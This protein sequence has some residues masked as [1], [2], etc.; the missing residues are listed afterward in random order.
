MLLLLFPLTVLPQ[1]TREKLKVGSSTREMLVYVPAGLPEYAPLVISMHGMNQDAAYQKGMANWAAVADTAKFVVVYPEGEG[2]SWDIGGDKDTK[3]IEAIIDEMFEKHHI[4][5]NRVYLSGF[6]MGGMM[7][8]HAASLISSKLAALAPISGYAMDGSARCPRQIPVIHT[9]GTD[10]DVVAYSGAEPYL[11]KWVSIDGCD[12]GPVTIK[13]YKGKPNASMKVWTNTENGIEVALLTLDGKGHWVSMDAS[14]VL[15]SCEI[16]NFC[17]RYSLDG[18]IEVVPP[19]LL[20]VTP[21]DMSFDLPDSC[22][23]FKV[24]FNKPIQCDTVS[25]LLSGVGGTFRL[26]LQEEGVSETLTFAL[27]VGV[28]LPHGEYDLSLVNV[29]DTFGGVN[30][31]CR[32][33]FGIGREPVDGEF[34]P[35]VIY[36]PD[37]MSQ[38]SIIGE[39]IPEG[40]K[41]VNSSADGRRDEKG[42]NQPNTG[43][44]RLKY[45]QPGGDMDAVFYLSARDY[46]TGSIYY[47]TYPDHRLFLK[48]GNYELSFN[49][50]YWT[51]GA[52][53]NAMTFSMAVTDL[54]GNVVFEQVG[55]GSSGA[56]NENV[57]R[58]ITGSKKHNIQ[59]RVTGDGYYVLRFT[60]SSGWDGV[61]IGNLDLSTAPSYAYRCK[62][63]FVQALEK[64]EAAV[65]ALGGELYDLSA[66]C[67][68]G[69]ESVI[70]QYSQFDGHTQSDFAAAKS[71]LDNVTAMAGTRLKTVIEY[72]SVMETAVSVLELYRDNPDVNAL[73]PYVIL[74]RYVSTYDR[75]FVNASDNQTV[76]DAVT[77]ISNCINNLNGMTSVGYTG[78]EIVSETYVAPDGKRLAAPVSGMNICRR[79]Y[80]DGSVRIEK[81]VF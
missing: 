73:R 46:D 16:W 33:S 8:Y 9:H 43:G 66:S 42:Q 2:K 69:Y 56:M 71:A 51:E 4:N 34:I 36:K 76:R 78:A 41:R 18:P 28:V 81:R 55:L 53:N 48:S 26:G 45:F 17:K 31:R 20:S 39:G 37:W 49:S 27:P 3:F 75:S 72:L 58:K 68:A 30:N 23:N 47:G 29:V 12:S 40:W 77:K 52:A 61:L 54:S 10:D 21:T 1:E 80:S 5:K 35:E 22:L 15:T 14:S 57:N 63:P 13:P 50:A 38:K 59:F 11:K 79:V 24:R 19:K 6:S 74:S 25:A 44:V 64:A 60:A 62:W 67:I 65:A 32:F 70:G 7:T